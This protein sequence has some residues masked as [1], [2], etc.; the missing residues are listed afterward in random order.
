MVVESCARGG[1]GTVVGISSVLM[2]VMKLMVVGVARFCSRAADVMV[3][4][5]WRSGPTRMLG[6][7][8]ESLMTHCRISQLSINSSGWGS[9]LGVGGPDG[10]RSWRG[11]G[12][13]RVPEG[14]GSWLVVS[15]D[16]M[17]LES[18]GLEGSSIPSSL[19][20]VGSSLPST[21]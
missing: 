18:S 12:G 19:Y 8:L 6:V 13:L 10:W 2:A 21:L 7:M 17:G 20:A 9:W 4:G 5:A 11:V 16:C 3:A 14:W 15:P 1:L